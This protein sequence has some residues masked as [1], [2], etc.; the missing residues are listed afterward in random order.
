MKRLQAGPSLFDLDLDQ[1]VAETPNAPT[2]P[3]AP[4]PAPSNKPAPT[5]QQ[6][7]CEVDGCWAEGCYGL[8][9]EIKTS[10]WRCRAHVWPDFL[11]GK[12]A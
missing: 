1:D 8:G 3:L 5:Y 11:P 9:L 7:I 10:Q 2:A 4:R 12:A 6:H